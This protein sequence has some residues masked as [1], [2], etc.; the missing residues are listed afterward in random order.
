MGVNMH[1]LCCVANHR[2]FP[3]KHEYAK[4]YVLIRFDHVLYV[5]YHDNKHYFLTISWSCAIRGLCCV[6]NHRSSYFR[7]NLTTYFYGVYSET[8]TISGE[9]IRWN[10]SANRSPSVAG[11]EWP[12]QRVVD[13]VGFTLLD[14][15][16]M[17]EDVGILM[18]SFTGNQERRR[19]CVAKKRQKKQVWC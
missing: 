11:I 4:Y 2:S 13:H 9:T 16:K 8:F 19:W 3:N 18:M 17:L 15:W 14:G 7:I 5:V 12:W 10:C 6:A 1:G